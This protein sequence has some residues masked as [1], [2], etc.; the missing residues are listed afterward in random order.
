[1]GAKLLQ[2]FDLF[3]RRLGKC[4]KEVEEAD[5][6]GVYAYMPQ[7]RWTGQLGQSAGTA[8][9]PPWNGGPAEIQGHLLVI[10]N[11]FDDIGV[12]KLADQR[13]RVCG[14]RHAG[15][16]LSGQEGGDLVDQARVYQGFIA[17]HIDHNPVCRQPQEGACFGKAVAPRGMVG[18]C[19]DGFDLM[20]CAGGTYGLAVG[21]HHD[22]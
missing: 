9:A 20:V 3:D 10:K 8:I 5:P 7:R 21:C 15:V 18:S 2:G 1:M 17:L 22:L 16:R 11:H 6:V 4:W 13:N 12:E 14:C 19:Q